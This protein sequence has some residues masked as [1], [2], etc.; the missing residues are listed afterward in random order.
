MHRNPGARLTHRRRAVHQR[1]GARVESREA[2]REPGLVPLRL[3][4]ETDDAPLP[5]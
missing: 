2:Q 5:A 4:L 3:G 1:F